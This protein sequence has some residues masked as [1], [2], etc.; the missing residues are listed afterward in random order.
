[1]NWRNWRTAVSRGYRQVF[2]LFPVSS[3]L[4]W[5]TRRKEEEKVHHR[6]NNRAVRWLLCRG[7]KSPSL[8]EGG[9]CHW[10]IFSYT[11]IRDSP[12]VS[13]FFFSSK[14]ERKKKRDIRSS[15]CWPFV[16]NNGLRSA[17]QGSGGG[18]K[19]RLLLTQL[20]ERGWI[21]DFFLCVSRRIH[22]SRLWQYLVYC[23]F[24]LFECSCLSLI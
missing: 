6:D 18:K 22:S 9:L 13:L 15:E 24:V 10:E 1:M 17:V 3:F 4:D 23:P 20:T 14:R 5:S 16:F 19:K 8:T 7:N 21:M 12:I 2:A 11:K